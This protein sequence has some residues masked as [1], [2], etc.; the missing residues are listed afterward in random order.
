MLF[1]EK[2]SASISHTHTHT[3]VS[4]SS[5]GPGLDQADMS[6]RDQQGQVLRNQ[7]LICS[8]LL[9]GMLILMAPFMF[10]APWG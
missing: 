9:L 1:N 5:K 6:E 8:G 4:A 3:G 2:L 7:A 10:I